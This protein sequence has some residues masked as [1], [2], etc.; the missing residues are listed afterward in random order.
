MTDFSDD[1]FKRATEITKAHGYDIL[2]AQVQELKAENEKL[3]AAK[4]ELVQALSRL[5]H[6]L[7]VED[8]KGME[9][10][11]KEGK[12]TLDKHSK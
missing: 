10:D 12:E 4:K 3:K 6:S 7:S 11:L 1:F 9:F 2:S 5:I 8:S